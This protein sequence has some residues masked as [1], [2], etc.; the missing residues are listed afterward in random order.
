MY[1]LLKTLTNVDALVTAI[2]LPVLLNR[3]AKKETTVIQN[4]QLELN[5]QTVGTQI[6]LKA[7]NSCHSSSI[8]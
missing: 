3:P 7:F 4:V 1:R 5:A 8:F 6:I 2:A